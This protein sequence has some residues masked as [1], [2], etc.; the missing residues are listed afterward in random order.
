MLDVFKSDAFS[1]TSLTAA[2]LKRPYK[3]SRIGELGLFKE[4]GITTTTVVIE[5]K[6][7][8]LSLIQS[9]PRGGPA[10]SIGQE[11]RT[12]RSFVVPH[13]E[14]ETKVMADE[15]QGVRSFGSEEST[16]AVQAIINERLDDLRAMHEVT[17]EYMRINAIQGII[18][19]ADGSTLFN[20]FT[21]FGVAQQTATIDVDAVVDN[22]QTPFN[23]VIAAQRLIENEVGA[24]PISGYRAFCGSTFF[25]G[26]RGDKA[27]REALKF[28]DAQRLI[29]QA[30]GPRKFDFAGVSWEEYR[31]SVSG[32]AFVPAAEAYLVPDGPALFQ[33]AFAPA[34]FVETVNTVGLP[35]YAK[36]VAD[37][38]LNRWVKVHTQSN[39]LALLLRPRGVVK[40]T[41]V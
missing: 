3:P 32:Q 15:V 19:D 14:R 38:E 28:A 24:E 6:N 39:P 5:E 40:L 37:P 12:A 23:N 36:I 8:R 17:L 21:E 18:K 11:K 29:N 27:I 34:D 30:S 41:L 26:L 35:L 16:D 31:G 2:I 1:L 10:S 33:T 7:G 22:G 13:F 4:K 9:S 20:L 25:D